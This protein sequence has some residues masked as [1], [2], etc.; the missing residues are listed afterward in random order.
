MKPDEG[1]RRM[2]AARG[3]DCLQVIKADNLG[4]VL[5]KIRNHNFMI[6]ST[7]YY[8]YQFSYRIETFWGLRFLNNSN[9]SF[10]GNG[11]LR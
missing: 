5:S 10:N 1:G 4:N 11:V 7:S 3:L 9:K 2:K 8:A 6:Y